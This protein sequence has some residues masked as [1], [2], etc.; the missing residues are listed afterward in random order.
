M[1]RQVIWLMTLLAV[2]ALVAACGGPQPAEPPADVNEVAP[3]TEAESSAS[4]PAAEAEAEAVESEAVEAEAVEGE[5]AEPEAAD[6]VAVQG[7]PEEESA[8]GAE[9]QEAVTTQSEAEL[10]PDESAA[11]VQ[12]EGTPG[13]YGLIAGPIDDAGFNQLAWEGMQRAVDEL[14]VEVVYV[15][16]LAGDDAAAKIN[17]ALTQG[18]GGVITVGA[19]L[20]Q[21]T[22]SASQANP[23]IPFVSIDF[24]S[25]TATDLGVVFSVDEPAFMAGY[26]AAGMTETGTVC[27]Y[28]GRDLTPVLSF[29]VGFENGVNY[30]NQKNSANVNVLGW[31]TDPDIP[32]GG[33]GLFID[34]FN[35]PDAGRQ[36]AEQLFDQGCDIVLPVAGGSAVGA[37]A[38]AQDRE[39]KVIG[40]DADQTLTEPDYAGVF[41]TSVLKRIDEVVFA[42]VS[43][44]ESG[45]LGQAADRFRNNY[46]GTLQ[47]EGVGLAPFYDYESQIPQQLM[48]D[49]DEI[50]FQLIE[51]S[52]SSGWPISKAN[53]PAA[54]MA[55][56]GESAA[57]SEPSAAV[58]APAAGA[59][60]LEALRNAEYQVEYTA[61]G[62]APLSNG[63]Y[64]EPAAPGSASEVVVQISDFVAFGDMTGDG[65]DEAAVILASSGGGSGT[66]YD[67]VI[68]QDQNGTPTQ[69]AS[70]FL[71]DRI[72]INSLTIEN[73]NVAVDMVTQGPNDPM[74]NPTQRVTKAY[75]LEMQ[76]VEVDASSGVAPPAPEPVPA[77][78]PGFEGTYTASLPAASSPGRLK[79]LTLD[80]DGSAEL[81]TDYQN[82][83]PPIVEVGTWQDNGDGTATVMLTGRADGTQ[84]NQPDVITFGL[85]GTELKA[86]AWD[87]AVYGSEGLTLTKQ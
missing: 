82:G 58:A 5:P 44:S 27:T 7:A 50:R 67:L 51:G 40:V 70:T 49:L 77:T 23:D 38:A 84:Y 83:K 25:Q 39:L 69:I 76:L 9:T 22:R 29:M 36:A 55:A 85:Q 28:G 20:A 46:V 74:V 1:K 64:R 47:N 41:L 62:T 81:S 80:A 52:L 2:L 68:M 54:Q 79:T 65:A 66:F 8:A 48:A 60:S 30:Y 14:G 11:A 86:I 53:V 12:T 43:L 15:E 3:V 75:Q 24:P 72:K 56:P 6:E 10:V 32:I 71:G 19:D 78:A 63:E 57:P 18:V 59:L 87:Q 61:S 37:A 31:R 33:E 35:D 21:A 73:G 4:E 13:K 34:A 45:E 26:L 42:A 17:E 16:T